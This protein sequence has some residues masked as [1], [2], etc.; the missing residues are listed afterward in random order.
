[1]LDVWHDPDGV[2]ADVGRGTLGPF[3]SEN[4]AERQASAEIVEEVSTHLAARADDAFAQECAA[5]LNIAVS[6]LRRTP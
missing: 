6:L 4:E 5:D 3:S 2:W 1:M